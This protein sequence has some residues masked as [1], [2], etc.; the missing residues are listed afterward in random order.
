MF[1]SCYL[2]VHETFNDKGVLRAAAVVAI[3]NSK[4][5]I[6]V[7]SVFGRGEVNL[8]EEAWNGVKAKDILENAVLGWTACSCEYL[9][10]TS[11]TQMQEH[12]K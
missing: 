6:R 4:V 2:S 3:L 10:S 12:S 1:S 9:V 8:E 7:S 5:L 11:I